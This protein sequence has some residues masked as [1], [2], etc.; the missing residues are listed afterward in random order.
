MI[1]YDLQCGNGHRFEGWFE[2]SQAFDLQ[3]KREMIACP[4]C[5]DT[6]VFK[7]PSTFAIK[8]SSGMTPLGANATA[9]MAALGKK[10]VDYV[11][12][13]FDNVGA[14][15]AEEALKMHYGVS[16]PRSIRGVSTPKEEATLKAEGIRFFKLPMPSEPSD[17]DTS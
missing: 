11:E 17:P 5:E 16:E 12:Q 14:D 10:I 4:V 2:D 13:N 8:G 3:K 15:F 7:L 1:A 6:V 9:N